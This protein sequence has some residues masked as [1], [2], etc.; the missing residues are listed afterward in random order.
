M[1][2]VKTDTKIG[3]IKNTSN[4]K[5]IKNVL[6]QLNENK[7]NVDSLKEEHRKLIKAVNY[8]CNLN[9]DLKAKDIIYLLKKLTRLH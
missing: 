4:F 6:K 3:A 7:V 9:Q 2:I 1:M 8:D 5:I